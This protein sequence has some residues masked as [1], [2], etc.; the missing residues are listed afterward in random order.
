MT[1][2]ES[3]RASLQRPVQL[4]AAHARLAE[5]RLHVVVDRVFGDDE[6]RGDRA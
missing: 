5:H 2:S 4:P 1:Q 6:P 3:G